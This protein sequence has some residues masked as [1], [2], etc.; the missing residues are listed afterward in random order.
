MKVGF[1]APL[2]TPQNMRDVCEVARRSGYDFFE[3]PLAPLGL[4]EGRHAEARAL[5]GSLSLPCTVAQSFLP[6]ELPVSGPA[7]DENRVK[8][9][10]GRAAELCQAV[11]AT[12]AVFGA[13]WSRNVPEGWDR[14]RAKEQL[15]DAFTWTAHAFEGSGCTVG[16]EPQNLKEANIVRTLPE[17]VEYAVAVDHP[18]IKVVLDFY[19]HDEEKVPLQDIETYGDWIIHI[20]TADTGRRHPG[21]GAY[22]YPAFAR[23]LAAIG[24]D[25][26]L[27]V[28]VMHQLTGAEIA[29]SKTFLRTIWPR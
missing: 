1:A 17:A 7:V 26:T 16:I 9:Y 8:T 3:F 2:S 24:Y 25:D 12:K 27:S 10:L 22:D 19:H 5:M 29:E 20:Q 13:A 11:G 6:R 4:H 14:A 28:E 15:I 21:T 18:S 23:H